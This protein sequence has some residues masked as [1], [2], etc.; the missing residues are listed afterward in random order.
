MKETMSIGE[1]AALFDLTTRTI[2]FYEE[3]RL[4]TPKR[5]GNRRIYSAGECVRLKLIL[6][7]KRLNFSFD[8]IREVLDLYR[9]IKKGKILQIRRLMEILGEK[10]AAL[11]VQEQDIRAMRAE[12]ESVEK[13]CQETLQKLEKKQ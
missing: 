10:R 12:I 8:E 3:M 13:L 2:R 9:S 1:V 7:G 5:I 11:D 6:R 4:I